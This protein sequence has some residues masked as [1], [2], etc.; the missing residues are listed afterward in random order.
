[1]L[2]GLKKIATSSISIELPDIGSSLQAV[3]N[4]RLT[5]ESLAER[6]AAG[7]TAQ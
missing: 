1:M 4:Y 6:G 2:S 3:R 5:Q 7:K